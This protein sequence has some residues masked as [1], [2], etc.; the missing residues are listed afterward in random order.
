M[1]E[2]K[3]LVA[4]KGQVAFQV[5]FF[6]IFQGKEFMSASYGSDGNTHKKM[7]MREI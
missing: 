7:K 6:R 3:G 2:S 5:C 1:H 4:A